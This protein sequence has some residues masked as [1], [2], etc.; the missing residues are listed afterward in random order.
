VTELLAVVA[1]LRAIADRLERMTGGHQRRATE[2]L[3]DWVTRWFEHRRSLGREREWTM[4]QRFV[5][6]ALGRLDVHTMTRDDVA[7]WVESIDDLVAQDAIRWGT[8]RRRWIFMRAM[9]RD[10]SRSKRRELR[11]RDDDIT[12]GVRGP[13]QGHDRAATFL[14]PDEVVRLLRCSALPV[15]RRRAYALA[16][17][18]APRAGELAALTWSDIDL[19]SGRIHVYRSTSAETGAVGPT[20]TGCDRRFIV[21]PTVLELLRAIRGRQKA[22]EQ[23][24][25]WGRGDA[26]VTLRRDLARAGCDRAELFAN[27]DQRRPINFHD[28]RATGITWWAM[29]GDPI[30]DIMER[31]GHAQIMTTQRYMRR[32][33]SL[34]TKTEDLFPAI[35]R[36]IF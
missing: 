19:R 22:H 4:Y 24:V 3:D 20:K 28:L 29:R 33:R 26:A 1:Q 27:D 17:Y 12:S 16:V 36:G 2:L 35:P 14:Y 32:G 11:V 8:A 31:V 15:A 6:P 34:A 21:E 7:S 23:V 30:G 9:L 13:D 18:I 5:S 10:L 25:T